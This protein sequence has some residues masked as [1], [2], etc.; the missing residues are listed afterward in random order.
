MKR[1]IP[2]RLIVTALLAV[3][4]VLLLSTCS[5]VIGGDNM[6]RISV[7]G[8]GD[9]GRYISG[10]ANSGYVVVL[11]G[12]KVYSLNEFTSVAYQELVNGNVYI[13]NLPVGTYIFGIVLL[14]DITDDNV[15]LAIKELKVEAGFNDFLIDVGPGIDSLMVNS[16]DYEDFFTPDGY[17]VSFANDTIIL[18][19][20]RN[21]IS[22]SLELT[23]EDSGTGTSGEKIIN[24]T[25]AGA[26]AGSGTSGDPW[27]VQSTEDGV[28]T[29][30]TGLSP[31]SEYKLSVI[32][33]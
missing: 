29:T 12:D 22:D 7:P 19:I 5:G 11:Q 3:A 17:N 4:S 26:A 21:P 28:E 1:L 8:M 2:D 23:F 14:D 32:L 20:D 10:D 15:G 24:G 33:K 6:V 25:T 16:Q 30:T 13:A 31:L 27:I 18:D 9:T